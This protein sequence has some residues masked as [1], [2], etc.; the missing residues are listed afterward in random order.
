VATLSRFQEHRHPGDL[1]DYI[2]I[3]ELEQRWCFLRR[4]MGLQQQ[5]VAHR[6]APP[7]AKAFPMLQEI[8]RPFELVTPARSHEFPPILVN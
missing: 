4:R 3:P 8:N 5:L 2:D 7:H 6:R 1:T